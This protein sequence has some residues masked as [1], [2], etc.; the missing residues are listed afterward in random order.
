M[1]QLIIKTTSQETAREI[2]QFASAFADTVIEEQHSENDD[3]YF[4]NNYGMNK[5]DFE[6]ELNKGIA[7]AILGITKPCE[8]VK[9]DLLQKI[10]KG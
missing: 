3:A 6:N 9:A 7:Q 2:K 4:I 5:P 8:N 10:N 1:E